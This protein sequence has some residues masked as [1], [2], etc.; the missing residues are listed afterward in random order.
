MDQKKIEMVNAEE[1][2]PG[3]IRHQNLDDGFLI[4]AQ[5]VHHILAPWYPISFPEFIENF[6]RDAA[7]EQE[8][9]VWERIAA[10]FIAL[11]EH[12][13]QIRGNAHTIVANLITVSMIPLEDMVGSDLRVFYDAYANASAIGRA[14]LKTK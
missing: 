3:P 14:V 2:R 13:S 8:L 5:L 10:A 6:Q 4:R 1:L 11:L 12:P 7:P 9:L